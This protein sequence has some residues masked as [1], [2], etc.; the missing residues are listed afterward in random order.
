MGVKILSTVIV[1][2][3]VHINSKLVRRALLVT[4]MPFKGMQSVL[5]R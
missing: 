3:R 5:G 4:V 1:N 2:N